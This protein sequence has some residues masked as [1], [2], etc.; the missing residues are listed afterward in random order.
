MS[1]SSR[2]LIASDLPLNSLMVIRKG[3]GSTG[4]TVYCHV[5]QRWVRLP[6]LFELVFTP[7]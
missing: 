5:N 4:D 1:E 6:S 3:E 2:K 7:P